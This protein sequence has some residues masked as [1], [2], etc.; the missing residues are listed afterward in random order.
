MTGSLERQIINLVATDRMY[1][2]SSSFDGK[3]E[4][5]RPKLAKLLDLPSNGFRGER[6]YARYESSNKHVAKDIKTGVIE[7]CQ[8][9]PQDG[10]I[11]MGMIEKH[12][13][14]REKHVYFGM[15]EGKRVH[16][17][18][19]LAVLADMG[20]SP[21]MAEKYLDVSLDIGRKLQQERERKGKPEAERRVLIG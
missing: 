17:D 20:L 7:Y 4:R 18:D 13:K 2:P 15:Q 6:A 9:F 14:K 19:Y 10:K 8:E 21:S 12:R 5:R 16:G 3:L 11:L 1:I